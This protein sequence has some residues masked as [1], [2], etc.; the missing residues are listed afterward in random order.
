MRGGTAGLADEI[1]LP[2]G[3]DPEAVEGRITAFVEHLV[4]AGVL[5]DTDRPARRSGGDDGRGRGTAAA[6]ASRPD[7]LRTPGGAGR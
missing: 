3:Q 2:A 4:A 6:R 7:A 5:V 1:A